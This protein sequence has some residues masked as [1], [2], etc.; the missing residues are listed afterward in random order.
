MLEHPL[1]RGQGKIGHTAKIRKTLVVYPFHD[2]PTSE[3]LQTH[4][5]KQ[6]FELTSIQTIQIVFGG[7]ADVPIYAQTPAL[8]AVDDF[9]FVKKE[10]YLSSC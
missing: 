5:L 10:G 4:L 9:V 6:R 1:P 7:H 8:G 2:L 3:W